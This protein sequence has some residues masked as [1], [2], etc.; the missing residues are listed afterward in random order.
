MLFVKPLSDAEKITLDDAYKYH[1]LHWTRIRAH[2]ILLSNLGYKLKDIALICNICR[3]TVSNAVYD[4]ETSGLCGLT[5]KNRI[6]R[7]K[8]LRP[9]EENLLIEKINEN[10][11]SLK[12]ALSAFSEF[13]QVKLSLNTLRN[14]CKSFGMSWKRIRKSLKNKRNQEDLECSKNI[15]NQLITL[16]KAGEINLSY[17]DAAGFSLTPSVPYAWQKKGRHIEIQSAKSRNLNVLGFLDRSCKFES[18]VFTDS[19][20]A[21]TV[22][23]CF[24]AFSDKLEKLTV[25]LVD[26]SPLHTSKKFDIKTVE[27]LKKGLTVVPIS[28]YSPELNMIEILWRK[29][30]YEWMPFSAYETFDSLES[31]LFNI[32]AQIGVKFKINFC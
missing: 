31:S 9:E 10:P 12:T 27:W 1:S 8:K 17:F 7:P 11:R 3:Q 5:D 23:S 30:K 32:L 29:I 18:F 15:V 13:H 25:V 26:N 22:I 19:I 28:K 16:Y 14:I 21:D 20:T 2:C 4:W 24:D 6:G